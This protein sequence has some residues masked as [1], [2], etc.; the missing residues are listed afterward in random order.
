MKGGI[1]AY[2]AINLGVWDGQ[3]VIGYYNYFE[4]RIELYGLE[5]QD[6][7]LLIPIHQNGP[8]GIGNVSKFYL[9]ENKLFAFS[10]A[11]LF[12]FNEKG[13]VLDKSP[14]LRVNEDSSSIVK[15]YRLRETLHNNNLSSHQARDS[16]LYLNFVRWDIAI[17]DPAYY[18]SNP[19]AVVRYNMHSHTFQPLPITYPKQLVEHIHTI[20]NTSDGRPQVDVNGDTVVYNFKYHDEVYRLV[21][22]HV[23]NFSIPSKYFPESDPRVL[24]GMSTNQAF[25]EVNRF[26]PIQYD[27]YRN[28][29]IRYQSKYSTIL[30]DKQPSITFLNID[31]EIIDEVLL[32]LQLK[33]VFF[34]RPDAIYA[35]VH[36]NFLPDEN[37]LRFRP[38]YVEWE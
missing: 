18:L 2:P 34:F 1:T 8:D 32:P 26:S 22:G 3:E 33:P 30:E 12:V 13:S 11:T 29:Y 6:S 16:F 38:I 28:I 7:T 31:L 17:T 10:N 20:S 24:N 19:H 5:G 37:H 15:T 9:L 25:K 21:D 36:D 4:Q 23:E 27:P 14:W 35:A